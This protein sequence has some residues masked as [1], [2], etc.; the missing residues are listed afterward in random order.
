L[1]YIAVVCVAFVLSAGA[2][3]EIDNYIAAIVNDSIIT[4]QDVK[5]ASRK[6][7]DALK[8]IYMRQPDLLREKGTTVMTEALEALVAKT[9]IVDE[10]KNS[11]GV[12]PENMIDNQISQ[13]IRKD[14]VDRQNFRKSLRQDGMSY[15]K[16]RKLTHDDMVVHFM[17]D[18]NVRS[19][20]IISP[21]KIENY[22]TN[23]LAEYQLGNQV[24]LRMIVLK[25]SSAPT[26]AEVKK[27]AL[28]V[29][30]QIDG[31][32]SFEEMASVYSEGSTKRQGGDWGWVGSELRKGLSDVAFSLKAGERSGL[33]GLSSGERNEYS[34]YRFDK[35]GHLVTAAKYAEKEGKDQLIEE[36][37][38]SKDPAAAAGLPEPREYYL[39]LVEDK[40][41]ARTKALPE[42]KDEIEKNFASEERKR[43]HKQWIDRLKAKAFVR[44][45]AP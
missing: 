7:I 39:M 18:R 44:Y 41:A 36:K 26:M 10:F 23:H 9:L 33:I 22:Y 13:Q 29:V 14:F 6:S 16:Y 17:L 19:A 8:Q 32:A 15:E 34:I 12:V 5:D 45:P 2:T 27:L 43:L 42:V 20:I 38:F 25:D 24:K 35:E 4:F 3:P 37:D 1:I 30:R 28:E 11:V 40:R 21:Q 31:G